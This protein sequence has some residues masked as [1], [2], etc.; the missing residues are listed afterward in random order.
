[1]VTRT[2]AGGLPA[3]TLD[4]AAAE[5]V[6]LEAA[7]RYFAARR[8]MVGPFVDR[9]FSVRGSAAI[10]RHALGWDLG[11]A[12]ANLVLAGPHVA[13][14]LG[15]AAAR[16][17]GRPGLAR[18]LDARSLLLETDV[19]QH[20]QWLIMTELLELPF[21]QGDR[22]SEKDALAEAIM[23]TPA[24]QRRLGAALAAIARRGD[25]PRFRARLTRA[26]A[27]YAG[28]RAAAAE[29]T[30]ALLSLGTGAL[31]LKQATPGMLSLGT[32]VAAALAHNAAVASFPLGAAA[33]GLWYGLFPAAVPGA[34]VVGATGGLMGLA[35][36]AAAFA[37]L[38]ADPVQRRLG[39][40]QRRLR[41]LIDAIERQFTAGD[42]AG[43]IVRDHYVARLLDLTDAF[44]AAVRA[45]RG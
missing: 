42:E 3:R 41:R 29:I 34:L 20:V 15:A 11:R 8:A 9:H 33:G 25:D 39:L 44:V 1:M 17:A 37:G 7:A 21:A 43:F 27:E 38:V 19:G 18:S 16:A 13:M 2:Q 22:T 5:A 40:H 28:S 36:L 45:A 14:K 32:S 23:A 12:P 24:V 26:L 30:T 4:E 10:H 35:A 6:V 31:A